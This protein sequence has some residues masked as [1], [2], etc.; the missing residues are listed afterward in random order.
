MQCV[1][2]SQ[3]DSGTRHLPGPLRFAQMYH[4]SSFIHSQRVIAQTVQPI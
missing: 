2:Q 4:M 1:H 3:A